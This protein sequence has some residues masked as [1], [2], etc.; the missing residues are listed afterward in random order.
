MFEGRRRPPIMNMGPL[1]RRLGVIA[2][3]IRL[4]TGGP[5]HTADIGDWSATF[6]TTTPRE[7]HNAHRYTGEKE[8]LREFLS[9]INSDDVVLDVG[10]NVG[11]FSCFALSAIEDGHVVAVE[12]HKPTAVR[13]RT[14]LAQNAS[15]N[16]WTVFNQ[17]FGDEDAMQHFR[18][19]NDMSGFP[20]NRVDTEGDYKVQV[21]RP[22]TLI[23]EGRLPQPDVIKIDVEGAEQRVLDGF[24]PYLSEVRE[25]F[26]ELHPTAGVEPDS[27]ESRLHHHGF[28]IHTRTTA[29]NEGTPLWHAVSER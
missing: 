26:I 16:I 21:H 24:G 20:S 19:K 14:N 4:K 2:D 10:A 7:Y 25:A 12:P 11:V 13:L 9:S 3:Q 15:E 18:V 29:E 5:L 27:I 1:K 6:L 28:T 17:A 23:T 22:E 8:V